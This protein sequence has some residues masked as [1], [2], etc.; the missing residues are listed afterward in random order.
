VY[1]NLLALGRQGFEDMLKRQIELA[2]TI[3]KYVNES[4]FYELL[5]PHPHQDIAMRQTHPHTDIADY[6]T[7]YIIVLFRLKNPILN[8]SLVRRINGSGTVYVSGTTF[9]SR[10][11]CRFAISNWQSSVAKDWKWIQ[12]VLDLVA[13]GHD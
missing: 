2:R 1:A 7:I 3:A 13:S 5:P 11:A 4:D 8:A 6:R 10:P 12:A 9:E